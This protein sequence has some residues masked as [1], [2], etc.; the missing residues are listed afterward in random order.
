MV[1]KALLWS[2]PTIKRVEMRNR[3]TRLIQIIFFIYTPPA[4]LKYC[5]YPIDFKIFDFNTGYILILAIFKQQ[6]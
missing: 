5:I 2:N 6:S 3:L 4:M 1:L